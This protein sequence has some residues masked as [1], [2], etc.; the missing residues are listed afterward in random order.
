MVVLES[1]GVAQEPVSL[2]ANV[3]VGLSDAHTDDSGYAI[4][5][6]VSPTVVSAYISKSQQGYLRRVKNKIGK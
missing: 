3:F 6:P 4:V 2:V 5:G 1:L